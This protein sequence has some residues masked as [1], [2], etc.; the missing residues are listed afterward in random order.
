MAPWLARHVFSDADVATYVRLIALSIP[1]MALSE[2]LG[3]ITRGFGHAMYYVIVNNL[4]PAVAFLAFL[5][6]M[7]RFASRP[8]LVTGAVVL[9]N[10]L[11]CA[12][13]VVAV[14]RV[15][16]PDLWRVRPVFRFRTLY[17][18]S[19][20]VMLNTVF[21][22]IFAWTGI[23]AV[24]FFLGSEKV[25]VYRLCF[26]VVVI[27]EMIVLAFHA[28]TGPIYPV[29]ARENRHAELE[30]TY[31]TALRWMAVLH[32]PIGVTLAW[33]RNDLLALLGPRFVSGSTALLI[34]AIGFSTCTCFG[35]GA[36]LLMLSGRRSMETWNAAV[37][38]VLNLLLAIVLVPRFDLTG[39]AFAA[40]F[41]FF[42]LN[43]ARIWEV[44]YRMGL[45][46]LRFNFV[47]ILVVSAG[48]ALG[49]FKTLQLLNVF[50]ARDAV[51]V[52]LRI[53]AMAV[54]YVVAVW[55]IGLDTHDK[56]ILRGLARSVAGRAVSSAST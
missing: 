41:S 38:A 6:G 53:V 17:E 3:S 49:S 52:G 42:V 35:T 47:R 54:A 18:Y 31:G 2:V 36:Y 45:R 21:Y 40:A 24:A 34:L 51:S 50:Q 5:G 56:E 15:A 27:L 11:G 9:A 55:G 28:A 13:G 23:L 39:A 16:G 1:F 46:T 43:V 32:V 19:S 29:L 4:V 20:G 8:V 12:T 22:M 7:A 44:R 33:N 26:Q 25:G 30:E 37:G 48:A 14:I 10:V